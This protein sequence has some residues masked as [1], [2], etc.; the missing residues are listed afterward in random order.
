MFVLVAMYYLG[1][2]LPALVVMW[3]IHLKFSIEITPFLAVQNSS[4]GDLVTQSVTS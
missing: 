1:L 4:K 2:G 3:E